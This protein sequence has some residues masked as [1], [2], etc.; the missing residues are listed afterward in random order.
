MTGREH[1]IDLVT[2]AFSAELPLLRLQAASLARFFDPNSLGRILV[3]VNNLDEDGCFARIEALRPSYGALA[4]R[5]AVIRPSDIFAPGRFPLHR[6]LA[7]PRL[8]TTLQK[9][10]RR[11]LF[12][13]DNPRYGWRGYSGWTVQQ[14]LKLAA[15]RVCESDHVLF[16][17]AKNHCV[18]PVHRDDF[19]AADGRPL[20]VT[21]A[22]DDKSL[23]WLRA[24]FDLLGTPVP[25]FGDAL[26]SSITPFCVRRELLAGCLHRIE[27]IAGPVQNLFLDRRS[28][29]CPFTEFALIHAYAVSAFGDWQA[30]F[31]PGAALPA[32]IFRRSDDDAASA[33]LDRIDRGETNILGIHSARFGT[34]SNQVRERIEAIWGRSGL[35]ADAPDLSRPLE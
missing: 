4:D 8:L 27:D 15:A 13:G 21:Q 31:A 1:Q 28:A 5:V 23:S 2:V 20:A 24:S 25:E 11:R 16:L 19:V 29:R 7:N 34:F 12:P 17:D 32:T 10:T 33:V 18:V 9:A 26:P 14:A 35:L 22:P 30:V 6:L 3:I